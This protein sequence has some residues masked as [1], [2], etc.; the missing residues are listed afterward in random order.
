MGCP[1]G[2]VLESCRRIESSKFFH[3][4]LAKIPRFKKPEELSDLVMR[5]IKMIYVRR[6][7]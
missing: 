6:K 2:N 1:R 5:S 7:A 3:E 4:S